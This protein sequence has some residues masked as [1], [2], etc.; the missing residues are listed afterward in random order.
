M[1]NSIDY[2]HQNDLLDIW[3]TIKK[4]IIF[5][6]NLDF[7]LF[8]ELEHL[9]THC[10]KVIDL[11]K[12]PLAVVISLKKLKTL[13]LLLGFS[14][15]TNY[16]LDTPEL[17]SLKTNNI[18]DFELHYPLKLRHLECNV[19]NEIINEFKNLKIL[20][21]NRIDIYNGWLLKNLND[22]ERFEINF[23]DKLDLKHLIK[24]KEELDLVNLKIIVK[25]LVI[26]NTEF[27]PALL[28]VL[29]CN[30]FEIFSQT[31]RQLFIN[32][33]DIL[34]EKFHFINDVFVDFDL[35]TLPKDIY[36]KFS[37]LKNIVVHHEIY[38]EEAWSFLLKSTQTMHT[39]KIF[40]PI[41]QYFCDLISFYCPYL[42]TLS[43][44][45]ANIASF[46][47]IC[48]FKNLERFLTD[49]ELKI[50]EFRMLI[51]ILKYN[52]FLKFLTFK[53]KKID[54]KVEVTATDVY[55]EYYKCILIL[56]LN[57]LIDL[58]NSIDDW[59]E[60]ILKMKNIC[61]FDKD[62]FNG[63]LFRLCHK[64]RSFGTCDVDLKKIVE[65]FYLS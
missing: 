26:V 33:Y 3:K 30:D 6:C 20:V 63:R 1:V 64:F 56:K 28:N 39:I 36:S 7:N 45:K 12:T 9:E 40:H 59:A 55:C 14:T 49:Q 65:G 34:Y 8:E 21:C 57:E 19:Y 23:L 42:N 27:S 15:H 38:D 44:Q 62:H 25:G 13:N 52:K 18:E 41:D 32:N 46:E 60:L 51:N 17:T 10:S 24:E 47:F 48:K 61:Q 53:F 58:L 43:I 50:D 4:L 16:V 2:I 35:M 22:L 37:N 54:F 29:L 31:N 5:N 11:N